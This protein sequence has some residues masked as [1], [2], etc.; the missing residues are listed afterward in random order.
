MSMLIKK[1]VRIV[2]SVILQDAG[3]ATRAIEI[4]VGIRDY[5][6]VNIELEIVFL[7]HGSPFEKRVIDNG[8]R[9][10]KCNPALPGKGFHSDFKT[11]NDN[12]IG[13]SD[14][15]Y[16]LLLGEIE[17]LEVL[18]PN[19]VLYGFWPIAGLGRRMVKPGIFGISYLPIPFQKDVFGT[20]LMKDVPDMIKPLANLPLGIRRQIIKMIPKTLKLK[21]P[22][23]KQTKILEALDKIPKR[24]AV[25]RDIF[26]ML[27]ADF[28]IIN[29]FKEFY[30]NDKIP[31][32]FEIV[33]PLYAPAAVEAIS[34]TKIIEIFNRSQHKINIFC[35]L[36]SSGK[37][38]YLFQVIKALKEGL[39][40]ECNA[41]IL[42]P[43][44][45]CPIKEALEFADNSPNIYLT[46]SFVPAPLVNALADVVISHGGQG[47]V[48]TAIASG[49]P[50]V[51]YAMQPEQ[52]I[53]LDNIV[54][55]G[56]G[57][58][59]PIHKWNAVNIQR[60]VEKIIR[61]PSYKNNMMLLK[62][63]IDATDGRKNAA[64]A[65]W[66]KLNDIL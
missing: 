5:C 23:L 63:V 58:R 35:S 37:K 9:I 61:N 31:E 60:A 50:I 2:F 29:D 16:N 25:V 27:K 53:N 42:A 65:I 39:E 28:T 12:I 47:T 21:A 8:F 6:P 59:I 11:T 24:D 14:L 33:G 17:A 46:D 26:D 48:Q 7:S 4:A 3:E 13:E 54:T 44:A 15:A 1:Q 43:P 30:L 56:A 36:G 62:Q 38:Q 34:D 51:G 49:T 32:N 18:K 57:I 66:N 55:R 40:K 64:I 20:T 45:V 41:V 19:V 52:Q 22:L 10:H